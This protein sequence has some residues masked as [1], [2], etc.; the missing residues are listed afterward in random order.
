LEN[1]FCSPRIRSQRR[2]QLGPAAREIAASAPRRDPKVVEPARIRDRQAPQPHRVEELEDG[3][4]GADSERERQ[5]RDQRKRRLEAQAPRAVAEV[6]GEPGQPTR[7]IAVVARRDARRG[8]AGE[9][10]GQRRGEGGTAR[11]LV[12]RGLPRRL[13]RGSAG[14]QLGVAVVQVLRDL[15]DDRRL[16]GRIQPETRQPLADVLA[17]IRHARPR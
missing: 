9:R 14:G 4:V 13:G 8:G 7:A 1:A 15:L 16:A 6:P 10:V 17:P 12:E 2:G 5:N 11:E 3:G